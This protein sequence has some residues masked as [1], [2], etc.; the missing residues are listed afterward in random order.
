[1]TENKI[2]V[3][4]SDEKYNSENYI[5][6]QFYK[7]IDE[8]EKAT[9]YRKKEIINFLFNSIDYLDF[10]YEKNKIF[11]KNPNNEYYEK[12]ENLRLNIMDD[13]KEIKRIT[14]LIYQYLR[15]EAIK[16]LI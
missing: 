16:K 3:P 8:Y 14:K 15:A 1:M 4:L 12:E 9:D 6:S 2:Y 10:V 11:Y 7:M 13:N 5:R